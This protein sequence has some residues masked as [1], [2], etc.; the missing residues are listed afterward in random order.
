M[1]GKGDGPT[2]QPIDPAAVITAARDADGLVKT[3]KYADDI[4]K[5]GKDPTVRVGGAG[6]NW[7]TGRWPDTIMFG[8]AD[9]T[10]SSSISATRTARSATW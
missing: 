2:A 6:N 9:G 4:L 3:V 1:M 5:S 10:G 7:L 8:G